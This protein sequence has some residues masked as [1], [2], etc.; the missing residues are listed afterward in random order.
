MTVWLGL[1][2]GNLFAVL[3]CVIYFYY[4]VDWENALDES[5]QRMKR[6]LTEVGS[7]SDIENDHAIPDVDL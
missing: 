7:K 6:T 2:S 5:V 3:M 1:G 4:R